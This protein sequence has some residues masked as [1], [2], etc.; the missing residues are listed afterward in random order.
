MTWTIRERRGDVPPAKRGD[1]W[2]EV[3]TFEVM[4]PGECQPVATLF[5]S[6]HGVDLD[7]VRE[8]AALVAA[9]EDMR[10]ALAAILEW[11]DPYALPDCESKEAD[12]ACAHMALAKARGES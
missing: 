1:A 11:V 7:T 12:V 3:V 5:H 10:A 2:R 6:G 8:R 9:A 4:A